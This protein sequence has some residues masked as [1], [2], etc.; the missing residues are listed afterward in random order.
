MVVVGHQAD[1][2]R[3]A[4][5]ASGLPGIRAV[6]QEEQRGT[7][8]AVRCALPALDGF[9]GDV[10]ILY[11]DVPLI[12]PE[13]L[14]R[15]VEAHREQRAQLSLLT[16]RQADPTGY[17][18]IV[19][20]PDGR[21]RGIVE[22]RDATAEEKTITEVNPG[23]YCVGAES[24]R[25]L[26]AALRDDNAQ[27]EFY[28]TDIVA[29]AAQAGHRVTTLESEQP[30]EVAGINTRAELADMETTLRDRDRRALDGRGRDVRGSRDRVRRSRG[31]DRR[32][33]RD[34]P[35]RHAARPHAHRPRVPP[36]RHVVAR[37]RRRSPT[38]CTCGSAAGS[39]EA[40]IGSAAVIGP[41]AR[42]RPGTRLAERVHIGNFV[43]TKK[44][45]IGA[46]TKA[47][48]LTY[49]G[50]CEVGARQQRRRR[51]HHLQL[52]RLREAPHAHR[53]ARADR[54][55]HAARRAGDASATTPTS[56]PARR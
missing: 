10:L 41:F 7:G 42:L 13:T 20:D 43:E 1:Q 28:L 6:L 44:A 15:L 38:A 3:D 51:H 55:R 24:L 25:P 33:H 56:R 9:S 36:R 48:H 26:L 50:D 49:L 8:H 22:E 23:V 52:R 11:G 45:A 35:E 40:E 29:L 39:S 17:G 4:A 19:R 21:V 27:R 14:R 32:R 2:V 34:R 18:R 46:G 54:Q 37:G 16:V 47:N 53:R 31:G 12:R 30:D 5:D